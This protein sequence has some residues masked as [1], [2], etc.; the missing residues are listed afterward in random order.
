MYIVKSE[1]FNAVKGNSEGV[2]IISEPFELKSEAL[3]F[4]AEFGNHPLFKRRRGEVKGEAKSWRMFNQARY[5]GG[6][7][8]EFWVEKS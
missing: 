7:I 4:A 2:E 6:L 5:G 8:A 1:Q 3:A